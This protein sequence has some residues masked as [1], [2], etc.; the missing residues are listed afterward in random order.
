MQAAQGGLRADEVRNVVPGME[1]TMEKQQAA[2]ER[3]RERDRKIAW[4][5]GAS[6][7][8]AHKQI[9]LEWRGHW[10]LADPAFVMSR[11]FLAEAIRKK[12]RR[13]R[14]GWGP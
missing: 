1:V 6:D 13:V 3:E 4:L 12:E 9:L 11:C 5:L 8:W 2:L 7:W 14:G 10:E